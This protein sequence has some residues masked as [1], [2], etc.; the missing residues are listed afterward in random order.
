MESA[1][2]TITFKQI[3]RLIHPDLNPTLTDPSVKMRNAVLFRDD[4]KALYRMGVKWGVIVD[5]TKHIKKKI[6]GYGVGAPTRVCP[7]TGMI[8]KKR[9]VPKPVPKAPV[10]RTM[11][12]VF[13]QKPKVAPIPKEWDASSLSS[14]VREGDTIYI[15]SINKVGVCL[16]LT[17]KRVYFRLVNGMKSFAKKENVMRLSL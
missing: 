13:G 11:G 4:E 6:L 17:P 9:Y 12:R 8:L 15:K 1:V 10:N 3:V 14:I 16:R 7:V 5:P 2:N